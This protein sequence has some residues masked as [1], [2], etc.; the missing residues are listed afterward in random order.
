M[1]SCPSRLTPEEAA[2]MRESREEQLRERYGRA[3]VTDLLQIYTNPEGEAGE[4][5]FDELLGGI[6]AMIGVDRKRIFIE[7]LREAIPLLEVAC[8][9]EE[10]DQVPT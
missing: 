6:D 10:V 8:A 1:S 3:I 2:A 9:R 4:N 7:V 5:P